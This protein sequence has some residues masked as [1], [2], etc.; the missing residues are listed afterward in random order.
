MDSAAEIS[1]RFAD[2]ADMMKKFFAIR[3]FAVCI[4]VCMFE[5]CMQKM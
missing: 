4:Q 2:S 1:R 5:L 3:V